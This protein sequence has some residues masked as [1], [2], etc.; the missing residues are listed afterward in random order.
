[1]FL[2]KVLTVQM[3][4]IEVNTGGNNAMDQYPI[5]GE[6]EIAGLAHTKLYLLA[7]PTFFALGISPLIVVTFM[8]STAYTG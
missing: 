5:R 6:V 3:G 1:M 7:L 2:G 8:G 4:T